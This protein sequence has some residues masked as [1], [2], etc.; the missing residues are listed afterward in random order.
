MQVL[1]CLTRMVWRGEPQQ[2]LCVCYK[3]V[4]SYTVIQYAGTIM[5]DIYGLARGATAT[6]VRVLNASGSGSFA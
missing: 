3:H 2:L 5:S 4:P 1:L 6:A